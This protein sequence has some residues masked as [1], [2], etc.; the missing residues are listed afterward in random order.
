[1]SDLEMEVKTTTTE[2]ESAI[3]SVSNIRETEIDA[4]R[5]Q[6]NAAII[7]HSRQ[8][9]AISETF[10]WAI[11][12]FPYANPSDIWYHGIYRQFIGDDADDE[13]ELQAWRAV[14]G[15]AFENFVA[16]YYS[17]RLPEFI[18]LYKTT[19]PTVREQFERLGG[20]EL[21]AADIADIALVGEF[22]GEK[23]VFGGINCLTSFKGR[24]G[25]YTDGAEVLQE[26]GLMAPVV[27]L[28]V[29]TNDNSIENRGELRTERVRRKP[30]R[31]VEEEQA[32][33]NLYS[34]NSRTDESDPM[35]PK[36]AVKR[37]SAP[38]FFDEF[39]YDTLTFWDQH[40]KKIRT[41]STLTL[42]D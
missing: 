6:L 31:L 20:T 23:Q 5:Q 7:T 18:T 17:A 21:S 26:N 33:S 34:F 14:S 16:T 22:K 42:E 39:L 24:L 37:V 19:D 12:E 4:I 1:M 10:L 27:T 38:S 9:H 41:N 11:E 30:A 15:E 13:S 36:H 32:F 8:R 29:Y 2:S 40:T 3:A 28:D 35:K 25:E